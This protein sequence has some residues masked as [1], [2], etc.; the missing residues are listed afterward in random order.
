MRGKFEKSG[1][2]GC[3]VTTIFKTFLGCFSI[4]YSIF[5]FE[6]DKQQMEEVYDLDRF[7][8]AQEHSYDQALKEVRGGKKTSHWI[9]YIFPRIVKHGSDTSKFYGI[10][11]KEEALAYLAHPILKERLVEICQAVLDSP[12][13]VQE[14][15]ERDAFKVKECVLL[16]ESVSDIPVFKELKNRYNWHPRIPHDRQKYHR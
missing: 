2:K 16:F 11:G 8:K 7:L 9:W 14:I 15:F 1:K 10:K 4:K 6:T 12:N 3:S 5:A 13:S